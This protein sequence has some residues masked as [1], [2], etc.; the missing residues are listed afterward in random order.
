MVS[1]PLC[2]HWDGRLSPELC[3]RLPP[4]LS[5][6]SSVSPSFHALPLTIRCTSQPA[7]S[8]LYILALINGI[9]AFTKYFLP[10]NAEKT[11]DVLK[12]AQSLSLAD[13]PLDISGEAFESAFDSQH[14]VRTDL[15]GKLPCSTFNYMKNTFCL[16]SCAEF[17]D[18][19]PCCRRYLRRYHA[20]T[21]IRQLL[22]H[23]PSY[24]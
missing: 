19:P 16:I 12:S 17:H 7:H 14:R 20:A 11:S 5:W 4:L 21:C 9:S 22:M 2:K 6:P 3:S 23:C 24:T 15:A 10:E 8:L 18:E 13:L 1:L